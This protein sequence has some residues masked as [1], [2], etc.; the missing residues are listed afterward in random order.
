MIAILISAF[1]AAVAGFALASIALTERRHAGAWN[2]LVE[3]RRRLQASPLGE[4]DLNWPTL[5]SAR[6]PAEPIGAIA[7]QRRFTPRSAAF[8]LQSCRRAAA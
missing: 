8:P 2:E 4:E 6:P 3:E 1:F 5:V 7:Y